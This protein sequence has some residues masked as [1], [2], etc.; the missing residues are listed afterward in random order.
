MRNPSFSN[1]GQISGQPIA[2]SR[3]IGTSARIND[4]GRTATA[5]RTGERRRGSETGS[6]NGEEP[7]GQDSR[8]RIATAAHPGEH[9]LQA[10]HPYS[11]GIPGTTV[12]PQSAFQLHPS[13]TRT[14][15]SRASLGP[16][17]APDSGSRTHW[18]TTAS[19][20][21]GNSSGPSASR[22]PSGLYLIH[23]DR[24]RQTDQLEGEIESIAE[25]VT[26]QRQERHIRQQS[27]RIAEL[28]GNRSMQHHERQRER[29]I[30]PAGVLRRTGEGYSDDEFVYG[31]EAEY[32][33]RALNSS[34]RKRPRS[35][36][37]HR[38]DND[39]GSKRFSYDNQGFHQETLILQQQRS[40][41]HN[42]PESVSKPPTRR[43][44]STHHYDDYGA[45]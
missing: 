36:S 11:H 5:E 27:Q 3:D 20:H 35:P 30:A 1:R 8:Y 41:Q 18:Q 19:S 6:W 21:Y 45:P 13:P 15:H 22:R 23:R 29:Q 7:L 14:N 32:S 31:Q 28:D 10:A 17:H 25:N 39:R 42:E 4:E 2:I 38:Q 33:G 44:Y 37:G 43:R 9:K 34:S 26:S 24:Y 12:R 40:L 16:S